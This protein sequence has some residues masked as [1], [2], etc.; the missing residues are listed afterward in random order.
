MATHLTR[1]LT[2]L[3]PTSIDRTYYWETMVATVCGGHLPTLIGD[4]GWIDEFGHY[5]RE[6]IAI[7]TAW[8]DDLPATSERV[9]KVVDAFNAELFAYGERAAM[10]IWDGEAVVA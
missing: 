7:V 3:V 5:V 2:L 4:G 9:R 6:P 1:K 8:C 10:S